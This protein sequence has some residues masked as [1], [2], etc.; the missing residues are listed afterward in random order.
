MPAECQGAHEF[1]RLS[2][3]PRG[4]G[5]ARTEWVGYRY[6]VRQRLV[7]LSLVSLLLA[8][9]CALGGPPPN[10]DTNTGTRP[11]VSSSGDVVDGATSSSSSGFIDSGPRE[12]ATVGSDAGLDAKA[13]TMTSV[14]AS[15]ASFPRL[16]AGDLLITEVMYN[17]SGPEPTA[18]WIEVHNPGVV[19][20]SL[21]GLTLFDSAGRTHTITSNI[22]VAPGAYAV[23]ARKTTD[24]G[25]P[26]AKI[27][28]E[29]GLGVPP[30]SGIQLTNS[31]SGLVSIRDGATVVSE[32]KYGAFGVGGEGATAQL[33]VPTYAG[34]QVAQNWC[35]S[36]KPWVAGADKGTPG[37]P[38][39]CP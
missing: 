2:P 8:G 7:P 20:R 13:D 32:A 37:E 24:T 21:L 38:S 10:D 34:S 11:P 4:G 15:D 22:M 27:V 6:A 19:S 1:T 31:N 25:V 35:T 30:G 5:L 3:S 29:Y 9:A 39:D 36:A 14:D 16:S 26:V 17:P 18:E 12:D 28:Y 23:L 33:K